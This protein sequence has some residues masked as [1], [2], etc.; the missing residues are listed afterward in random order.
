[1]ANNL[2]KLNYGKYPVP[3]KLEKISFMQNELKSRGLLKYGDLLGLYFSIDGVDKR[4]LNTPLDVISFAWPAVDGM[5]YGFLTDFGQVEDLEKALIVRV[6]PMDFGDPV[7][8]VARNLEDFYRLLCFAP[9]ALFLVDIT[10]TE[11]RFN[12]LAQQYPGLIT[13]QPEEDEHTKIREIFQKEFELKPIRN[14]YDYLQQTKNERDK[15]IIIQTEDGIGVI[16]QNRDSTHQTF[17][18]ALQ[19]I[20]DLNKVKHFFETSSY[21]SKLA[22]FRDAQSKGLI[23]DQYDIK[24][25]LKQQLQSLK[26]H[27]EAER[28]S[29]PN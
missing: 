19:E 21:E 6:S 20:L 7:K 25:Y 1:M 8:I 27:D 22:F 14:L 13:A 26:L 9:D 3:P 29:Y 15:E 16:Q 10:T 2:V 5:H 11:D 24:D 18:M 4:Y 28:I 17:K 12:R 23:F